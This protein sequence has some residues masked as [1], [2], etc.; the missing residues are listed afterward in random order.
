MAA[1]AEERRRLRRSISAFLRDDA[2]PAARGCLVERAETV[3]W[4]EPT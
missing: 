2:A 4:F 1:G 3:G